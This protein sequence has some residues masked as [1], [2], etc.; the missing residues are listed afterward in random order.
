MVEITGNDLLVPKS[1]GVGMDLREDTK[2]E[3]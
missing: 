1:V 3:R 2:T